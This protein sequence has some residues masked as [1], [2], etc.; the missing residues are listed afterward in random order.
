MIWSILLASGVEVSPSY[1]TLALIEK[2]AMSP[3]SCTEGHVRLVGG[4]NAGLVDGRVELCLG[5]RYGAVC[6]DHWD[7]NAASVL[8]RERE[9]SPYGP[10]ITHTTIHVLYCASNPGAIPVREPLFTDVAVP[11]LVNGLSCDGNEDSIANCTYNQDSCGP[12]NEAGVVC[13]GQSIDNK[14][15]VNC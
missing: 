11:I 6:S 12:F 3:A 15:D 13:Q 8:C 5:G 7:N 9:Q 2:C 14:P 4:D 1:Q 10:S